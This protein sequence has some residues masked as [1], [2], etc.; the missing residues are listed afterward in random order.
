MYIE[1]AVTR[2]VVAIERRP[3]TIWPE[4]VMW[5]PRWR[6]EKYDAEGKLFEVSE[7]DGNLLLNE[8]ITRMLN[9]LIGAGGTAYNNANARIGVG[10]GTAAESATQTGLQGANQLYKG[11]DVGYPQVSGTTVTFRATF[12]GAEANFA[13]QE[14]SVD[15]GA[16]AA[17]NLNRKVSNQ[18]TKISG[19]TWVVTL[20]ITLS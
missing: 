15:N 16:T 1:H 14:F 11:M 10:D 17:E 3:G 2:D 13:W 8:G 19:Q 4:K 20:Q 9:L 12:G 5:K 7:F 6:I 18:G